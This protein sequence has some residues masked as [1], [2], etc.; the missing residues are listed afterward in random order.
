MSVV[1]LDIGNE[2]CVVA[3]A[4]QRGIDVA[5]ND[6][7]KR[8]TPAVVCFGEKQRFLGTAAAAS[9]TMNPKTTISQIKRLIGRKFRDPEVQHD[10][11][12]FP[13]EAL[14]APDGGI[15]IQ[16]RYMGE[17]R[18]FTPTQILGMILSH[19]RLIATKS[20]EA[21]VS[22]CVI[23][24]PA[25]FTEVQRRAYLDAASIAKLKPLRLMHE[26][27]AIALAY[28]IYRTDLPDAD[29]IHVV[30]V[31]IGHSDTQVCVAAFRKGQLKILSHAFERSLGGRDFDEILFNYF[32][33]KFKEEYKI[34]V[35]T[36][37]R[38]SI[39][40]RAACEKLKKVLSANAEA[41]LNI[42][43]LMEEKDVRGFIKREEFEKLS[44]TLLEKFK[45]P[46]T[47]AL[48]EAN[49]SLD[50]IYSLEVVGSGSR[51][52]AILRVLSN[53]FKREPGRTLN[54][55][56]CIARG[57]ALQ[58]AMLSPTFRVRE[59]QVQDSFPFSIALSW[60]GPA[61]ESDEG[62]IATQSNSILF[63][64]GNPI[65]S[66]KVLTFYRAGTFS[67]D[68]LY[69]DT[70]DLPLGT[71][72][73]I[74]TFTIGPFQA[75]KPEKPKLKVRVRLNLHGI[76][77]I[78]SASLIEEE[79][80]EVP[81]TK[82]ATPMETDRNKESGNTF[83]PSTDATMDDAENGH[84]SQTGSTSP[85][86][87]NSVEVEP[88]KQEVV[89]K[90][91]TKRTDIPVS[92]VIVGGLSKL[93]LQKAEEK[94]YELAHN[95]KIME[96]TKDSKNAVEAYVYDMRNKLFDKYRNYA[97]ETEREELSRK[98]QQTE[99]WLYE[100]GDDETRGVYNAKLEELKKIGDP[101]EQRYKEE[102]A[103]NKAARDLM[104]YINSYRN[105]ALSKD[106]KFDHIDLNEKEK[107][108]MECSKAEEW[109]REK[110]RQ[111]DATPKCA[112]PILLSGDIRKKAET[113]D[114]FCKPIMTKPK[115][116]PQKPVPKAG[117][118]KDSKG[119]GARGGEQSS[120]PMD[121]D[122][123]QDP[124]SMQTE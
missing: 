44:S 103:R 48:A 102:E 96:D 121:T 108:L 93:E 21:A 26:S 2:N 36:N 29:P 79:E 122:H 42:E 92:E 40:L 90:K 76:V 28:G 97:T 112:N 66:T 118:A 23:G 62:S 27:T 84:A 45:G 51:I 19:L 53:L 65:P 77:T 116:T 50:K 46:C 80:V 124:E 59:F 63:P 69:A 81:V 98:L 57:C 106:V 114:M 52:P 117:D 82:S 35:T 14:E 6:E 7:S 120:E 18:R 105:A 41:P 91:R 100:E 12:L 11:Q 55:S 83:D 61:S 39:R 49:L 123:A 4:K 94:E 87:E 56:E 86:A 95:D 109:L 85:A 54:A 115:P 34:D 68:A 74:S 20:L 75:S 107:V 32:A 8:E 17:N 64:R 88:S 111:Q 5:L 89:K 70:K 99:D 110:I 104:Y 67:I 30:F 113:L 38:A 72:S 33:K 43:C 37:L 78:E 119:N 22:D 3:V 31:D 101:I 15:L 9:A 58:C 71:S 25:Y 47:R 24:I 13:F 1:G 10:L 60:K 16:V 73:K